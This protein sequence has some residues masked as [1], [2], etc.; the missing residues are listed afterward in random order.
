MIGSGVADER[1]IELELA[2]DRPGATIATA[3]AKDR[4]DS[5]PG[6]AC[7]RRQRTGPQGAV[8]VE[9]SPVDVERKDLKAMSRHRFPPKR[10]RRRTRA[11]S[12]VSS[13]SVRR[14]GSHRMP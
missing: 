4:P 13:G 6:R 8:G 1:S 7:D 3:R 2:G 12:G 5:C 14:R 10:F 11:T 9:Q